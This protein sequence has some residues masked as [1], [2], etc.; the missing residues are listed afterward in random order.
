[1]KH[2]LM[3]TMLILPLAANTAF[4]QETA[5]ENGDAPGEATQPTAESSEQG[6][7]ATGESMESEDTQSETDEAEVEVI[8]VDEA[9]TAQGEPAETEATAPEAEAVVREQ[10]PNELRVDWITGTQVTS[11]DGEGIGN[12]NDLILDGETGE[13]SA[14]VLSVGG[15]L[16]IGA[17]QIAVDWSELQIDYDANEISLDM[18][19]EQADAAPEYVFREQ[20]QPPAPAPEG[21]GTT[22]T[23]TGS[24]MGT[25]AVGDAGA[26][27]GNMG[28]GGVQEN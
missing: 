19:R 21:T 27:G 24:G 18:T 8:P 16:G 1:M 4:A 23:G 14:A 10:A 7:Q 28:T 12:I 26:G 9:E 3:T 11:P 5:T 13:M 22:G 2:L 15:F 25:G 17:K 20:E 6:A